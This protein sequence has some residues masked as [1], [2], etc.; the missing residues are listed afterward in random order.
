MAADDDG[1][2]SA[3]LDRVK[4][5]L[6]GY[7]KTNDLLHAHAVERVSLGDSAQIVARF[8][9]LTLGRACVRRDGWNHIAANVE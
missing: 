2:D 1:I 9:F 6:G 7:P 4:D 8:E 5:D 3:R